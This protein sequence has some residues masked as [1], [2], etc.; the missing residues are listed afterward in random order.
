VA[1]IQLVNFLGVLSCLSYFQVLQGDQRLGI[2][3]GNA[4]QGPGSAAL[5][6]PMDTIF[7]KNVRANSSAD[8]AG[9]AT[10]ELLFCL[11]N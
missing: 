6:E 1:G 10:G 7:V 5:D 4:G 3:H 9:L 8:V 11:L 2:R